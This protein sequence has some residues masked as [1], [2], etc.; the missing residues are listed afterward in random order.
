MADSWVWWIMTCVISLYF[1]MLLL[2]FN[3]PSKKLMETI[4]HQESRRR[5]M[6]TRLVKLQ[7]DIVQI[8]T[9]SEDQDLT[10]E[11]YEQRR[12]DLLLE[13]NKRRMIE[14]PGGQFTMGGSQ[15]DSP[16]SERPAHPVN[17][18]TCYF[19]AYPVTNQDYR[20]FVNCTGYKTPIH[21]QRGS[22][23]TGLARHPVVNVSY[24]DAKAYA[25]WMGA[26]LPTEAEWEKAA[27]GTDERLYPWGNRF[28]DD[29]CNSNGVVG[30]TLMVDEYP[31][32]R[33]PY[34]VWDMSGNV[35]E[36]CDD[37]YDEDYY[38]YSPSTNPRGPEGGQERVIRGGF[39]SE[40]RPNVRTTH[41]SSAPETHTRENVGF[42]LAMSSEK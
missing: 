27:R 34:G 33:S 12:K 28:V 31:L 4:D 11:D 2:D 7:E 39:F 6:T 18:P 24:H 35:Y 8:K 37:Y 29:R 20:E 16:D 3:K 13:A 1:V 22:Y 42:R 38:K 32:G 36:W 23:P 21:W 19:D 17:V 5:E 15:E 10:M 26:R 14:I 40:T 25:E 30:T 9:R 41:R